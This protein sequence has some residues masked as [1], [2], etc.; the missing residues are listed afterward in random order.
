MLS[1]SDHIKNFCDSYKEFTDEHRE[2]FF[3]YFPEEKD[4]PDCSRFPFADEYFKTVDRNV[5]FLDELRLFEPTQENMPPAS[6]ISIHRS[7]R[8]ARRHLDGLH[9]ERDRA[10]AIWRDDSARNVSD[11]F[12]KLLR[13]LLKLHKQVYNLLDLKYAQ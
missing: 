7:L 8:I 3:D 11:H 9:E 2:L 13:Y 4:G 12:Q 1:L 6:L 10:F 5:Q